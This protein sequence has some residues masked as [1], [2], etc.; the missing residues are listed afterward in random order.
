MASIKENMKNQKEYQQGSQNS[1]TL[2][3]VSKEQQARDIAIAT[4]I[5]EKSLVKIASR[6]DLREYDLKEIAGLIRDYNAQPKSIM[7]LLAMGRDAE[8]VRILYDTRDTHAR[9]YINTKKY[10]E[11]Y[12][13]KHM[14]EFWDIF[15]GGKIDEELLDAMLCKISTIRPD[16]Y[17]ET[18]IKFAIEQIKNNNWCLEHICDMLERDYSLL[19]ADGVDSN[20]IAEFLADNLQE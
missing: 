13:L 5:N 3:A 16:L 11:M 1:Q 19:G 10:G 12:C 17:L 20:D 9:S 8:D 6:F 14:S 18:K 2:P 4:G 15:S 7:R